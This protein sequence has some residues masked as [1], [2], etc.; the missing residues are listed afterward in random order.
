MAH[1]RAMPHYAGCVQQ[2]LGSD[3]HVKLMHLRLP[4]SFTCEHKRGSI[5]RTMM[6]GSVALLLFASGGAAQTPPPRG[7]GAA[8]AIPAIHDDPLL[9]PLT[10]TRLETFADEAAVRSYFASVEAYGVARRERILSVVRRRNQ[11]SAGPDRLR[12]GL[13]QD[14]DAY[15]QFCDTPECMGEEEGEF[16]IVVTAQR[17][18]ASR[19]APPRASAP[20][21]PGGAPNITNVQT[22]GVDEGDIVKQIGSYLAVLQDGRIFVVDTRG[23][24]LRLT[25]RANVYVHKDEGAWYDEM[26]VEGDRIIVTAYSYGNQA[27]EI[28]VFRLDQ[29]SGALTREGRFFLSSYDYYSGENYASRIVGDNL[30]LYTIYSLHQILGDAGSAPRL[31]RWTDA[32]ERLRRRGRPAPETTRE[33]RALVDTASLYRPLLRTAQPMVH[34]V[35]ICPLGDYRAGSVPACRVTSFVGPGAREFFVSTEGIYL[36]MGQSPWEWS[37]V[38]AHLEAKDCRTAPDMTSTSPAAVYRL[39][40]DGSAPGIV[41]VRGHPVDQ[42]SMDMTRDTFRL[43]TRWSS[44]GCRGAGA[45]VNYCLANVPLGEFARDFAELPEA[46][47]VRVPAPGPGT[48]ENRF[49]DDWFVYGGRLSGWGA[50][51]DPQAPGRPL[52]VVPVD[53]PQD[54]QRVDLPHNIIRIERVGADRIMASGYRHSRGLD[55]SL[56]QLGATSYRLDTA[57]LPGR[58]ES[59]GRSHAFNSLI[60]VDGSGMMGVPTVLSRERGGR[61]VWNSEGSD[62]SFLTVTALGRLTDAGAL[63]QGMKRPAPGYSCAVSCVDWYGNSRPIFTDG[64]IFALMATEIAE[65][66]MQRGE[67]AEVQ[68]LNLTGPVERRMRRR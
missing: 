23:S 51:P 4:D 40:M 63:M 68:R 32:G 49:A 26:L 7:A 25:D 43:F 18:S 8:D 33:G 62:V 46:R 16:Q 27:T 58:F 6:L 30:V 44:F 2:S 1:G 9:D 41:G 53:R 39:P 13:V 48:V 65:G 60:E 20:S 66:R 28:S 52:I 38:P 5:M 14:A 24:R 15:D 42:F 3:V 50:R 35:T 21:R 56:I 22:A 59:E 12:M 64:R 61:F 29:E 57:H 36:W 19:S 31:W 67:I 17:S 10:A 54:A 11:R 34:S 47:Q 37:D 45:V 55:L